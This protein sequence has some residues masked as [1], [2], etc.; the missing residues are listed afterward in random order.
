MDTPAT[1]TLVSD[2]VAPEAPRWH[3]G[4]L[5]FSDMHGGQVVRLIDGSTEV[6]AL[7]DGCPAGIGFLPDGSLLVTSQNDRL[8]W[9][10][11]AAGTRVHADLTSSA[12]CPINDMWVAPNGQAYVGEMGFDIHGFLRAQEEGRSDGPAFMP[13]RLLLVEPDGSHRPAS[14]EPF[15][16]PNG[17]IAGRTPT[18]IIIA[19]SFGLKLTV[20]DIAD[21]GMLVHKRLF[22][23]LDFAPDGIC[24][25]A[26]GH[27]WAAD[28]TRNQAVLVSEGGEVLETVQTPAKCLSVGLGGPD[29]HTLFLATTADTDP[30]RSPAL[31][32][33]T[34]ESVG[35][36]IGAPV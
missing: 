15:Y 36:K 32:S 10:V 30:E 35:V 18:E 2:L 22:A 13:A 12:D 7:I 5:Y 1:T 31:R 17:I 19:E 4:A 21:D 6:L 16:F 8:I 11:T 3:D 29:G 26:E 20:C 9:R 33:G 34:I 24:L 25:D 28:P 23:Q 27:V 14:D